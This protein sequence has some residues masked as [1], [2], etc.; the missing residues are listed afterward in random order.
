M[1]CSTYIHAPQPLI[2]CVTNY[3][4]LEA[5]GPHTATIEPM[6]STIKTYLPI[7]CTLQQLRPPQWKTQLPQQEQ[8]PSPQLEKAHAAVK[9][10]YNQKY[11]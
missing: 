2:L 9:I 7:A 1:L 4:S 5:L 11:K 8:P 6:C 10:Q 3:W